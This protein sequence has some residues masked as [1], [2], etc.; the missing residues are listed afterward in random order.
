MHC[1]L[2]HI[3]QLVDFGKLHIVTIVPVAALPFYYNGRVKP[4][5]TPRCSTPA[6]AFRPAAGGFFFLTDLE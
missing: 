2:E 1:T 4:G 5:F 6:A 3:W